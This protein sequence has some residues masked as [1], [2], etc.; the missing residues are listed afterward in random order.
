MSK[1]L[2]E[3]M[4]RYGDGYGYGSG[5]GSGYGYGSGDGCGSG[6]GYGDGSGDGSAKYWRLVLAGAVPP[7]RRGEF[8]RARAVLAFWKSNDDGTPANGGNG[9]TARPGLVQ[10]VDGPLTLCTPRALH[11][12]FTPQKWKGARTWIVAMYPPIAK[13]DGKIGSLKREIVMESPFNF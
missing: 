8:D 4:L 10:A 3:W 2:S 5:Y 9:M 1:H 12:T 7:H 6:S 11:A 13:E